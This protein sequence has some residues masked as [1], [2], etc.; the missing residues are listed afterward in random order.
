MKKFL[1]SVLIS[2]ALLSVTG[3]NN[4]PEAVP[5]TEEL[6]KVG[7]INIARNVIPDYMTDLRYEVEVSKSDGTYLATVSKPSLPTEAEYTEILAAYN[8]AIED[9]STWAEKAFKEDYKKNN[10][11]STDEE[12][13]LAWTGYKEELSDILK[14]S[15]FEDYKTFL[16]YEGFESSEYFSDPDYISFNITP[17]SYQFEIFGYNQKE[18]SADPEHAVPVIY[19]K[20]TA[21]IKAP[22]ENNTAEAS[23]TEPSEENPE[24]DI[25]GKI[26]AKLHETMKEAFS[27]KGFD[28]EGETEES[29]PITIK[30]V[31]NEYTGSA[32][33]QFLFEGEEIKKVES[34]ISLGFR[35][36]TVL[37]YIENE[38]KAAWKTNSVITEEVLD[39][40]GEE[41]NKLFTARVSSLEKGSYYMQWV[42]TYTDRSVSPVVTKKAYH[43]DVFVIEN[44]MT[45]VSGETFCLWSIDSL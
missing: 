11:N 28:L 34:K 15:A 38:E 4:S 14:D 43:G 22:A 13:A 32:Q 36:T 7:F 1:I 2:L 41:Y 18:Y 9:F 23:A 45:S 10:P 20:T 27:A 30:P 12:I 39:D 19:G 5:E 35:Y 21:E 16:Q 25:G 17:G 29:I 37:D 24:E 31:E 8:E 33:S 6:V 40:D 3:C 42:V 26:S 44:G